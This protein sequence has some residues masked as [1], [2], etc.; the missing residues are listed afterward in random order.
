MYIYIK[1]IGK[2]TSGL[3]MLVVHANSENS[4]TQYEFL[5]LLKKLNL[6]LVPGK[7]SIWTNSVVAVTR[8]WRN[9]GQPPALQKSPDLEYGQGILDQAFSAL[10]NTFGTKLHNVWS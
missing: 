10:P 4:K 3:G 8:C 1:C 6:T 5:Y 7:H 2:Y 9:G